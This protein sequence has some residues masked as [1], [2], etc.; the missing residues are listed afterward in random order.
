MGI[1]FVSTKVSVFQ[2]D[3]INYHPNYP[4]GFTW[5]FIETKAINH[6][7]YSSIIM[8]THKN[9]K[10]KYWVVSQQALS[11]NA[12]LARHDDDNDAHIKDKN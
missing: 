10:A 9:S 3:Q 4:K 1:I 2:Q 8:W 11:F 12:F 6:D 7:S 5:H